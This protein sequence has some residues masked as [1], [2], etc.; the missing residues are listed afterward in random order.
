MSAHTL[1]VPSERVDKR[2]KRCPQLRGLQRADHLPQRSCGSV[3]QRAVGLVEK[4][5]EGSEE[6]R[7]K[8]PPSGV[9]RGVACRLGE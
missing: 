4:L 5:E 9:P 2:W 1:E 8:L 6:Q 3:L 7:E